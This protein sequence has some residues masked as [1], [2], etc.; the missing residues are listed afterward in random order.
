MPRQIYNEGRVVGYSAYEVYLKEHAAVDPTTTP[1]TEREWLAASIGSGSSMLL[2]IS[3]SDLT[4]PY[5]DAGYYLFE[6]QLPA[7]SKLCAANTIV[8]SMFIGHGEY[9]P[10]TSWA[11]KVL[12]Y[13]PLID[14]TEDASPSGVVGPG[15]DIPLK[16]TFNLSQPLFYNELKNYSLVLDGIL[17]QPG[18]WLE[19]ESAPPEKTFT[20]DMAYPPRVRILFQDMITEPIEIM[21]TGFTDRTVITGVSGIEGSHTDAHPENGGF[22]GPEYYPWANKIIFTVPTLYAQVFTNNNYVRSLDNEIVGPEYL[23]TQPHPIGTAA[24][25]TPEDPKTFYE[26]PGD[27]PLIKGELNGMDL[28]LESGV[29][30]CT[31]FE[32]NMDVLT[33][34]RKNAKYPPALWAT[35]CE[36]IIGSVS[37]TK[38]LCPVDIVAPGSIKAIKDGT[39]QEL[40]DYQNTY[41]GTTA[42]SIAS[43]GTIAT[44]DPATSE[45]VPGAEVTQQDITY[46]SINSGDRKAQCNIVQAGKSKGMMLSTGIM[47]DN[48]TVTQY[49]IS[50]DTSN[51]LS[52]SSSNITWAALLEGLANDKSVDI[53][54]NNMKAVKNGLPGNYIQFPNG[55]RLYISPTQPTP[56]SSIPVGS[57]GIGWS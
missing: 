18:T 6:S 30:R 52:P 26:T 39:A 31:P 40:K 34:C 17:I 55:L 51:T 49:T 10:D 20:P 35:L 45:L 43:D 4:E 13:G 25:D 12:S 48:H 47:N 9:L 32:A 42:M 2:K 19:N 21:L 38:Y 54:G 7:T 3:A 22:L 24:I 36:P 8:A 53:L 28:V 23:H 41:P 15:G 5:P 29:V 44:V 56:S 33:V 50:N 16:S 57:I 46:T 27:S 14:N 11:T 1:A 37:Q